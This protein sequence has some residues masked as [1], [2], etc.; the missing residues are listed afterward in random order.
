MKICG[1]INGPDHTA[2]LQNVYLI[3][4]KHRRFSYNEGDTR[5]SSIVQIIFLLRS[6]EISK[7]IQ[8]AQ[9]THVLK[10]T[11]KQCLN[12]FTQFRNVSLIKTSRVN[13]RN[14]C[15]IVWLPLPV[16]QR[17]LMIVHYPKLR[18]IVHPISLLMFYCIQRIK[19]L[20]F[21]CNVPNDTVLLAHKMH[22]KCTGATTSA[23]VSNIWPLDPLPSANRS[24]MVNL[25]PY[26]GFRKIMSQDSFLHESV[27]KLGLFL[28]VSDYVLKFFGLDSS[29]CS[30]K[31]QKDASGA[32][33]QYRDFK[34]FPG[35]HAMD[36]PRKASQKSS[37]FIFC[38]SLWKK[39][40]L[41]III[42]VYALKILWI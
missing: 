34:I 42:S 26:Q 25:T 8:S 4:V 37:R 33:K 7:D 14:Y 5:T 16:L 1:V 32:T 20:Y 30:L 39:L 40:G 2:D 11:S 28:I 10:H 36:T 13:F 6:F 21:I 12:Y 15:T 38:L 23:T 18:N 35:E 19:R 24:L 29:I 3:Y 22:N 31:Y 9:N 41:S 27:K 17:L